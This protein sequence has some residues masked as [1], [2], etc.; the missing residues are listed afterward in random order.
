MVVFFATNSDMRRF[1]TM[2]ET[3]WQTKKVFINQSYTESN[4]LADAHTIYILLQ[5]TSFPI[6]TISLDDAIGRHCG[7]LF[8]DLNRAWE[9]LLTASLG[10]PQ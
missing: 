4:S 3:L 10:Y 8:A 1:L 5:D 6:S 9:P 2:L 7:E